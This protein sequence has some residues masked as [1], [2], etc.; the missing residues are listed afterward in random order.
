MS[1]NSVDP[2]LTPHSV[3]SDL[4]L[5]FLLRPVPEIKGYYGNENR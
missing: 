4:R 1:A 3:A 5:H 2:D